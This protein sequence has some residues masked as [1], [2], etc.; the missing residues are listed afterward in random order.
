MESIKIP[1]GAMKATAT[2]SIL[3]GSHGKARII[4]EIFKDPVTDNGTKKSAKGLMR[5]E[6]EDDQYVMYD[7]QTPEEEE[8]GELKVLFEDGKFL[9]REK[10]ENIRERVREIN[11]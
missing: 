3:E 5:I 11:D 1:Y 2:E 9:Y 7:Q 4:N 8:R 6:L 10:F